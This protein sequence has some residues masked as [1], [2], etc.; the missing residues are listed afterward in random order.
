MSSINKYNINPISEKKFDGIIWK[1]KAD[2]LAPLLAIEARNAD[3]RSTSISI[4]NIEK[5]QYILE[6]YT[7]AHS[8]DIH[9]DC[10]YKGNLFFHIYSN[11]EVP[12]RR[13]IIVYDAKGTLI[14][15]RF[16]KI[17]LQTDTLGILAAEA[18]IFPLKAL[19]LN[20][21]TGQELQ[22]AD[23]HLSTAVHPD[24]QVPEPLETPTLP[25]PLTSSETLCQPVLAATVNNMLV[26]AFHTQD[27]GKYNQQLLLAQKNEILYH[28]L[29]EKQMEKMNPEGFFVFEKHIFCIS[30]KKQRL[31]VIK[32]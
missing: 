31:L 24:I 25:L 20:A 23:L 27:N 32:I 6:D 17:L 22:A 26:Y 13:G 3:T 18:G 1:I 28:T 4:Y 16:D 29:L 5:Q 19:L 12:Q 11:E 7:P 21:D 14:W 15:Q 30:D 2:P 10:L 9:L 8:W